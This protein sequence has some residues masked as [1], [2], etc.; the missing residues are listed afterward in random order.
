MLQLISFAYF[1][2]LFLL[3]QSSLPVLLSLGF[4][5]ITVTLPCHLLA[6]L[7]KACRN[8]FLIKDAF[9]LFLKIGALPWIVGWF[10]QIC[11]SPMFGTTVFQRFEVLSH[12]PFIMMTI[13]WLSGFYCLI[14][15]NDFMEHIQRVIV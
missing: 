3:H 4:H 2:I 12:K 5:F 7:V 1:G 6:F 13:R 8:M 11:I 14:A 15:A 9:V 10:L